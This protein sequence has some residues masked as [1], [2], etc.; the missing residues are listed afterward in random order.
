MKLGIENLTELEWQTRLAV[1]DI[2][3]Q[4]QAGWNV[5]YFK[6]FSPLEVDDRDSVGLFGP[7]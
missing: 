4:I 5:E 2:E 3:V 1:E 7:A 6:W